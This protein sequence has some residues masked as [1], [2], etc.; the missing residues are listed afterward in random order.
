MISTILSVPRHFQPFFFC[1]VSIG[2]DSTAN[3]Q[4]LPLSVAPDV[5]STYPSADTQAI[6]RDARSTVRKKHDN[7]RALPVLLSGSK[8]QHPAGALW[9]SVP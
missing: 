3:T 5:P 7:I 6:R 2:Y 8:R 1:P 9:R 4:E